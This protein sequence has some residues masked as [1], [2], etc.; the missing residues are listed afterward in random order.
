MFLTKIKPNWR[1]IH[2]L[3]GQPFIHFNLQTFG[4]EH[5]IPYDFMKS[6][7][8]LPPDTYVPMTYNGATRSRRYANMRVD[9]TDNYEYSIYHTNNDTFIQAVDDSR[10]IE[11]TFELM[12]FQHLNQPWL[13]N[14]ITQISALSVLNHNYY[15]GHKKVKEVDVHLHQVRQTTY[16]NVEAHNSPEGIHRDGADY[17]VSAFVI[18]RNNIL[19]G[20]SIIYDQNK[21]VTYKTILDDKEGIYQEDIKQWHYVTPIQLD[22]PGIGFRDILGI[23][24]TLNT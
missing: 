19:G 15:K 22:L 18:H 13:T 8:D 14:F 1:H 7:N 21:M 4:S 17:I 24:I 2:H 10:G 3:Q 5:E 6:Y 20:E 9:V 12:D 23:D 11:R 16:E